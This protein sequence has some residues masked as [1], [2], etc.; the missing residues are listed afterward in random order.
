MFYENFIFIY[1]IF[2]LLIMIPFV[3]FMYIGLF[4]RFLGGRNILFSFVLCNLILIW[5]FFIVLAMNVLVLG[6]NIE[7]SLFEWVDSFLTFEFGFELTP[8]TIEMGFVVVVISTCVIVYSFDYLEQDPHL[9][10]FIS[11]LF[12]FVFFM[13]FLVFSSNLLQLF[14]GWEGVGLVSFL[15][16][17]FWFTRLEANRSAIKAILFNRVGD[18]GF[19]MAAVIIVLVT[20]TLDFT[21]LN[22]IVW[23]RVGEVPFDIGDERGVAVEIVLLLL[24]IG[25]MGKSAQ[26]GLHAWLPDAMEGPTP[27]SAL[28]HSATMVTVGVFVMLRV[29]PIVL[30]CTYVPILIAT[31]GS[32]TT[33]VAAV[34]AVF[35]EDIKKV[36]AYSTCSQLGL[37]M[38]SIG[39]FNFN[40]SF[41]HLTTHAFFKALLFLTAGCVIHAL[42]N[43]QDIRKMG[44]LSNY[45]PLTTLCTIVGT[46]G[47]VG[48]PYFSGFYSKEYILLSTLNYPGSLS[49]F[50]FINL[51]IGSAL[52]I[53]YSCKLV[54]M[55][56]YGNYRGPKVQLYYVS[57]SGV[58][59][60]VVLVVLSLFTVFFGYIFGDLYIGL[61]NNIWVGTFDYTVD[62]VDVFF[63]LESES[64]F[65]KV[66]LFILNISIFIYFGWW[67][68][69]IRWGQNFYFYVSNME[70]NKLLT[71]KFN[72][73]GWRGALYNYF[74]RLYC[75]ITPVILLFKRSFYRYV[76]GKFWFSSFYKLLASSYFK[77]SYHVL[78][79]KLDRGLFE[80]Y[81]TFLSIS[82]VKKSAKRVLR[83]L[84]GLYFNLSLLLFQLALIIS[85]LVWGGFSFIPKLLILSPLLFYLHFFHT[86]H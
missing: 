3:T 17:N 71:E 11:Y 45:L 35:Q 42:S 22:G 46:L 82:W 12:L 32:I 20:G 54:Y 14:I 28:L 75:F 47:L 53:L 30:Q 29:A 77:F 7:F 81:T 85:I 76:T 52:T 36:I 18:M 62:N 55:V 31:I 67:K 78:I 4:G 8:L 33:L 83:S 58:R 43:E 39:T 34:I 16:I 24:F 63:G 73:E 25:A 27:V 74:L 64:L 1:T 23:E 68:V 59:T 80:Y 38:T 21:L 37:L 65:V 49:N 66:S 50:F 15:L 79:L 84:Q 86:K 51:F 48:F 56:F 57:D 72:R 69:P 41:F 60:N 44:G 9:T 26:L 40:A 2:T 10:R 70:S 13:L 19:I 6:N 5:L 61:G